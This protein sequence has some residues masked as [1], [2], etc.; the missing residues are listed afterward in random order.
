MSFIDNRELIHEF[1][2][3]L[4]LC[5]RFLLMCLYMHGISL[6]RCSSND[7]SASN[8]LKKETDFMITATEEEQEEEVI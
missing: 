2:S 4:H 8:S 6:I 1:D 3:N 5:R 7:S